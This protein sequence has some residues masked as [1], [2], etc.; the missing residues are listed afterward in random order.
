MGVERKRHLCCNTE[1]STK[2]IVKCTSVCTMQLCVLR[3]KTEIQTNGGDVFSPIKRQM[4][5]IPGAVSSEIS[6]TTTQVHHGSLEAVTD[7]T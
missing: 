2:C 4:A 3:G 5:N 1:A 6:V 7:N